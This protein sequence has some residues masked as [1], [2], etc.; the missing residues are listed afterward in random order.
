MMVQS[1]CRWMKYSLLTGKFYS[2]AGLA[3]FPRGEVEFCDDD[4]N[5]CGSN[6]SLITLKGMNS[7]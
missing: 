3:P 2:L 5:L 6:K 4:F 7:I 1:V